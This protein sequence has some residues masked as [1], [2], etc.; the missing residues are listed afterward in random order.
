MTAVGRMS[1]VCAGAVVTVILLA[2]MAVPGE[3][4]KCYMCVGLG[5]PEIKHSTPCSYNY[6]LLGLQDCPD[7][8]DFCYVLQST[9]RDSSIPHAVDR[10]CA[11]EAKTSYCVNEGSARHCYSWCGADGC[12]SAAG[13]KPGTLSIT[14]CLIVATICMWIRA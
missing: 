9:P 7:G 1:A 11:K 14:I 8:H 6:A 12:N 10:G 4:R 3:A 2:M 5:G 13:I